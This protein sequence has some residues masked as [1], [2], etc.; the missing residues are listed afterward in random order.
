MKRVILIAVFTLSVILYGHAQQQGDIAVN[1]GVDLGMP[2]GNFGDGFG[3]GYGATIKGLY[4]VSER[5]QVG[6]N[7]GYMT[8]G[9]KDTGSSGVS[10]S[11][12]VIPV[13]ALYRHYMGNLYLEPQVGLSINKFHVKGTSGFGGMGTSNSSL[14]YA[15]GVGYLINAIDISV[16]YQGFSQ[17]SESSGFIGLR[18]A[19]HFAFGGR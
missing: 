12:G 4:N 1:G 2:I 9:V 14:G 17:S 10:A 11:M 19:Y 15:I 13:F 8:F 5:G 16:R 6:V 3:F 7:L 18:V